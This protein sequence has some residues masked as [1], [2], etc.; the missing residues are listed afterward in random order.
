MDE[1]IPDIK[2]VSIKPEDTIVIF[3]EHTLG[4][5]ERDRIGQQ[6]KKTF[7]NNKAVIFEAGMKM[8][9]LSEEKLKELEKPMNEKTR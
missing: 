5:I 3:Y 2:K 4:P 7:P 8:S 1:E 9:V 6:L